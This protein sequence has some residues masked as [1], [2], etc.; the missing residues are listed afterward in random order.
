MG[1]KKRHILPVLFRYC[2]GILLFL[3]EVQCIHAQAQPDSIAVKPTPVVPVDTNKIQAKFDT[4]PFN[5]KEGEIISKTLKVINNSGKKLSFTIDLTIPADWK[6]LNNRGKRFELEN[7]DTFF[8][9]VR[10]M[11]VGK[12][13]GNT[14]Y[15]INAYI[16][17]ND[18]LP[19]AANH[20]FAIREKVST[21]EVTS[22]PL[23]KI[24]F[25]NKS[26]SSEFNIGIINSGNEDQELLLDFENSR[27][28]LIL[29]D[30]LDKVLKS[31]RYNLRLKPNGDTSFFYHVKL[32]G[33]ERNYRLVDIQTYK[34][35]SE[36]EA[37]KYTLI[38]Q[39]SPPKS[40]GFTGNLK[41]KKIE[42]VKL[43]DELRVNP[44]GHSI[45]PIIM[46]ANV[47]NLIGGMPMMNVNLRGNALL[48]NGATLMYNSQFFLTHNFYTNQFWMNSMNNF[49][50]YKG[51]YAIQAGNVGGVPGTR[52][53]GGRGISGIYKFNSKHMVGAF[54]ARGPRFFSKTTNRESFGI[55]YTFSPGKIGN[56]AVGY[57]NINNKGQSL[58]T[59]NYNIRASLSIGKGHSVGF[60]FL[61]A[62]NRSQVTTSPSRQGYNIFARYT[63]LFFKN[64][65]RESVGGTYR[66]KDFTYNDKG[67][68]FFASLLSSFRLN[69]RRV[70]NLSQSYSTTEYKPYTTTLSIKQSYFRNIF[71]TTFKIGSRSVAP[72]LFYNVG[73]NNLFAYHSRGMNI[74]FST[75]E[76]E[77]NKLMSASFSAGYHRAIGVKPIRDYFFFQFVTLYRYK[78][79]SANLRYTY[80]SF[81]GL[82][83]DVLNGTDYPQSI[84][85]AVNYQYQFK[86]PHFVVQN[87]LNYSYTQQLKR[88]NYGYGPDLYYFTNSGWRFRL[89][90]GYFVSR[91]NAS[92]T[93]RIYSGNYSVNNPSSESQNSVSRSI[94]VNV[95][96]RKEF[97]IPNPFSNKHFHTAEFIAFI[98]L[99][100]NGKKE[101]GE[102]ALEN[103]VVRVAEWEVLTNEKGRAVIR[104]MPR[105][106]YKFTAFS[107]VELDGFF[108]NVQEVLNVD[109]DLTADKENIVNVPFVKGIN[110]FG[111]IILDREHAA[112]NM[113][114]PIDL[115]G[116]KISALNGKMINTLTGKNGSF[117]FY[118]PYGK[119]VLTMDESVLGERFK[120]LQN[121]IELQLD[122][123]TENLFVTFYVVEKRRK[124]N[125]KTFGADGKPLNGADATAGKGADGKNKNGVRDRVAE[126]NAAA[127]KVKPAPKWD[128]LKDAMLKNMQDATKMK[129][130]IYTIQIGAFQKP[131]NPEVFSDLKGLMYERIDNNFVRIAAGT[132]NGEGPAKLEKDNL[133]K[134]GFPDSFVAAYYDGKSIS[135]IEAAQ[136]KKRLEDQKIK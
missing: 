94:L 44:F 90:V 40:K 121:N 116:I 34:P 104:N 58:I 20:F 7:A 1:N 3:F 84:G 81:T 86:D 109:K 29:S 62:N 129:G 54:Y 28:E 57:T 98:D 73:S 8:I 13:R 80:G 108:P 31:T 52:G 100:G 49:G 47:Y 16:L 88:H 18:S 64:K 131:L 32:R 93:A 30:T 35:N 48:E 124:I 102:Y 22:G 106:S 76:F 59:D 97:G 123:N 135:L 51:K 66:S 75:F 105:E 78:T 112:E 9:P 87:Y 15:L 14:K 99:N 41:G 91:S 39:T 53:G 2:L 77:T 79:I 45:F 60:G 6:T 27:Q 69:K 37:T 65:L 118:I 71:N 126:A 110:I 85:A 38:A 122:K 119:Y 46:E 42:F 10:I 115:S 83:T 113:E 5:L 96:A 23:D 111:K 103:V 50:Y 17:E 61:F 26:N 63:G 134:V 95:G 127:A 25:L 132:F 130:L 82:Y 24:Y 133:I 114:K 21:W 56:F 120:V 89:N 70:F 125:K 74:S 67:Y 43:S 72:G 101:T 33:T 36:G 55:G 11:P 12:I 19:V 92:Q 4:L 68:S 107:L 136:I 117:S 128:V